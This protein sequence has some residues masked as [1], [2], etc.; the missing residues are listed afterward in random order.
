MTRGAYAIVREE[1]HP[2]WSSRMNGAPRTALSW[3]LLR[4]M[5]AV[6]VFD[7]CLLTVIQ[8]AML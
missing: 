4:E 8:S 2:D 1:R 5:N 7:C 6:K 3:R